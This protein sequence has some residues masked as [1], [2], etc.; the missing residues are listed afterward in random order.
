M[1][2]AQAS[3]VRGELRQLLRR[4]RFQGL[5]LDDLEDEIESLFRGGVNVQPAPTP[6]QLAGPTAA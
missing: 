1:D 3:S 4:A 2:E 5:S 6:D